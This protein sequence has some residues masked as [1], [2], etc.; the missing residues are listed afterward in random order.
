MQNN[1]FIVND[2]NNARFRGQA[3]DVKIKQSGSIDE[4]P[5]GDQMVAY[6]QSKLQVMTT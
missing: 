2:V 5:F 3:L 4:I 6:R 1:A